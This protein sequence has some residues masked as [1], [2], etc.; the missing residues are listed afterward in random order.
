MKRDFEGEREE[1]QEAEPPGRKVRVWRRK[2]SSSPRRRSSR[3]GRSGDHVGIFGHKEHGEFHAGVFG[4]IARDQLSL[5]LW[6]D[7]RASRLVSAN[8]ATRKMKKASGCFTTFHR[9]CWA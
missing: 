9:P 5:G 1:L 4:V 2:G 6:Q 3:Q 8:T 7:Q